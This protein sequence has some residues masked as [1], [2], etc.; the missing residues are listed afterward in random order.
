MDG[1][2]IA[3]SGAAKLVRLYE[4]YGLTTANM[5]SMNS[6]HSEEG[7]GGPGTGVL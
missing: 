5:N 1:Y 6:M 3:D 7:K 2:R 4:K